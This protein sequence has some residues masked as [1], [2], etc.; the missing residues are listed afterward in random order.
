MSSNRELR[1]QKNDMSG[2]ELRKLIEK[3]FSK[4]KEEIK[5]NKEEID[6][7]KEEIEAKIEAKIEVKI[8]ANNKEIEKKIATHKA[9]VGKWGNIINKRLESVENPPEERITAANKSKPF[10]W[11]EFHSNTEKRSKKM[12]QKIREKE[13]ELA[14]NDW[15]Q[16]PTQEVIQHG[17]KKDHLLRF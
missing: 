13:K 12:Q 7:N 8:K 6:K 15:E 14:K 16:Y 4:N 5:A 2:K 3:K 1:Q 17:K 9:W 10:D 11:E